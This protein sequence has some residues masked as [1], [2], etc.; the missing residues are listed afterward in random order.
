MLASEGSHSDNETVIP[1]SP[2]FPS[3]NLLIPLGRGKF[4]AVVEC[5]I[6]QR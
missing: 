2:P 3:L 4:L 1:A 6:V 5:L